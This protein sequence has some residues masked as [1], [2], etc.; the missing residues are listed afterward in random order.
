VSGKRPGPR[1][2]TT[3]RRSA[4]SRL[5]GGAEPRAAPSPPADLLHELRVHQVELEIQNEELR[6]ARTAAEEARDR[7]LDLYDFAPVGYLTLDAGG[8][9]GSVNL[10][11]A[12]LLG[13]DRAELRSRAFAG[14]VAPQDLQRWAG[15]LK[16]LGEAGAERTCELL[17]RPA[18]RDSFPAQ[19]TGTRSVPESGAAASIR[20]TLLDI[21]E[22]RRSE[23][24]R[25]RRI[26]ELVDLNHRLE[27]ARLQLLRADKLAAIGQLAAGVAHEINNPLTYAKSNLYLMDGYVR[28]LLAATGAG[29]APSAGGAAGPEPGP[30]PSPRPPAGR[31]PGLAWQDLLQSLLEAREGLDR[32]GRVVSDLTAFSHPDTG[33][34]EEADLHQ[35]IEGALRIVGSALGAKARLVRAYCANAPRLRCR[36]SRLEQVFMNILVN[37]SQAVPAGGVITVRTGRQEA[38]TWVEI[39]DTGPGIPAEDL[40]RIFEPF[41]TTKPVGEGTGVG[42]AIAHEI[43]R[44]HSG[45]IEVR[46][47][48]GA[49]TT[50][51]VVLPLD[52][53]GLAPEPRP[54]SGP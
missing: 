35:V 53:P 2:R 16:T 40:G 24:E 44:G 45:R 19:L 13:V 20:F 1:A 8:R 23:E 32:I 41:F 6:I 30:E 17:L 54:T 37:A 25:E 18:N 15:Y 29:A 21:S 49:G 10:A 48:A 7:Y 34:W 33:R 9:I 42:L 5:V 12:A 22:R 39:E 50:F 3:L 11:G 31:D 46:S 4:E 27:Q 38:E 47:Q 14:F 28:E 26:A 43:V 51:R 52:G 36:P